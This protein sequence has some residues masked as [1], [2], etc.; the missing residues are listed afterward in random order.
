MYNDKQSTQNEINDTENNYSFLSNLKEGATYD[1]KRHILFISV[2]S[3]VVGVGNV[4]GITAT[5]LSNYGAVTLSFYDTANNYNNDL[6]YFTSILDSFKLDEGYEYQNSFMSN[7]P[8]YWRN[9]IYFGIIGLL[10]G[11]F[12]SFFRRKKALNN[13]NLNNMQSQVAV[14]MPLVSPPDPKTEITDIA[15]SRFMDEVQRK[16]V[17]G[18]PPV[19]S[20]PP[21]EITDSTNKVNVKRITGVSKGKST[22]SLDN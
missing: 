9:I 18:A 21:P 1:S 14:D 20:E 4:Q 12:S 3:N 19:P 13:V 6:I 15:L 2:S 22:T 17:V 16:V 11:V 8:K 10:Y 7:I 5:K